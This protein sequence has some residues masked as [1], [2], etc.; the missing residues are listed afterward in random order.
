MFYKNQISYFMDKRMKPGF[1]IGDAWHN[2]IMYVKSDIEE[3]RL[4]IRVPG[5]TVGA[6]YIE[7]REDDYVITGFSINKD[8]LSQYADN[9]E[10]ML[11]K[12]FAGKK[13][14]FSKDDNGVKW[15]GEH[16]YCKLYDDNLEECRHCMMNYINSNTIKECPKRDRARRRNTTRMAIGLLSFAAA[17][18]SIGGYTNNDDSDDYEF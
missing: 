5:Y 15:K 6:L 18:Q 1:K 4:F 11:N 10:E 7:K 14:D 12:E 13:Y 8:T 17:I 16:M 9:I 2:Y 3:G